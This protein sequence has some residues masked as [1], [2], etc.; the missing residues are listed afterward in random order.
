M[1][2]TAKS[3]HPY[4]EKR[5]Q[6]YL[7]SYGSRMR[8]PLLGSPTYPKATP[9][10]SRRDSWPPAGGPPGSDLAFM[11]E[12]HLDPN[13]IEYGILQVLFPAGKDVRNLELGGAM[14][15]ALNEW[16]VEEWC[17]PE[18]RLKASITIPS[19]DPEASVAEIERCAGR[20]EFASVFMTP[21]TSEPL[22]RKRYWPIYE[23]AARHDI[24]IGMHTGGQNGI[25]F[26]AGGWPSF[27]VE[28]HH[29][30]SMAMHAA[31][32]SMIFEGVFE[33]FPTLRVVSIEAGFG[34]VPALAW[35]LDRQWARFRDELPLC[36]RPPSEYIRQNWWFATQ[37]VEEPETPQ[38]LRDTL[39]WIGWDRM[40]F[41]SDYPHWDYDDPRQALKLQMTESEKRMLLADNARTVY[42]LD[43]A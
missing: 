1:L 22:G 36:K 21:R 17:R 14:C 18:P 23:A 37:P 8:L 40:V 7:E 28:E 13:G 31:L 43:R 10:L 26:T 29:G 24:T 30:G 27:Y 5:W 32:T 12:Q 9:A 25:P 38:Q 39:D 34:W 33:K 3:L 20:K 2:R 19:D 11:R 35:R 15:R 6:D 16:Q 41:S 42:G 4:M